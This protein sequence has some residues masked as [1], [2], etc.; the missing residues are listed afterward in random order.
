MTFSIPF[1]KIQVSIQSCVAVQ[2]GASED[3]RK[4]EIVPAYMLRNEKL[5]RSLQISP[6]MQEGLGR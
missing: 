3:A 6:A 4:T 2:K 5:R 1:L